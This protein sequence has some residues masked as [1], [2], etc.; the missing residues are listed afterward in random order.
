MMNTFARWK[1]WDVLGIILPVCPIRIIGRCANVHVTR[2]SVIYG[3]VSEI[4]VEIKSIGP[5]LTM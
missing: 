1:A 5:W 3:M 4:T 2:V